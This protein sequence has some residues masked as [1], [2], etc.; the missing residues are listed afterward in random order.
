MR[1]R[2]LNSCKATLK[3]KLGNLGN[4]KA[5]FQSCSRRRK[6]TPIFLKLLEFEPR[7]PG[8]YGVLKVPLKFLEIESQS[9]HR[10][11]MKNIENRGFLTTL[12][13]VGRCMLVET[14]AAFQKA[15]KI[16]GFMHISYGTAMKLN[17]WTY[18][19]NVCGSEVISAWMRWWA[20][21]PSRTNRELQGAASSWMRRKLLPRG[22]WRWFWS[23]KLQICRT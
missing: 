20:R 11:R 9:S 4:M 19:S 14:P 10:K 1:A 22:G 2:I 12:D 15:N 6:E 5:F 21:P 8:C 13:A 7:H 23:W 17:C 16:N 3:F 18:L